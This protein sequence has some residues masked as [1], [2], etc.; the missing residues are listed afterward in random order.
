MPT[1]TLLTK[2]YDDFQLKQTREFLKT[3]LEGLKISTQIIGTMSRGW[4][5]IALSGEDEKV[6]LNFLAEEIGICPTSF[7]NIMRFSTVGGRI[8]S[9]NSRQNGLCIDIGLFSPNI[10]DATI[11]LQTLQAQIA[12]GRKVA[13]RKLIEL[14]GFLDDIPLEVKIQTL[15][16]EERRVEAELAERQL[17][18]YRNWMDSLLDRLFVCGASYD[19]IK[20]A[21]QNA[22]LERDIIDVEPL[23]MFEYAIV[24]KLGTDARGLIP[25]LGK[26]LHNAALAVFSPKKMRA[27][28]QTELLEEH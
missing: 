4:V 11:S 9:L 5:Q 21:L 1:V 19:E 14:F 16:E 2:A 15:K 26:P 12:K 23:G 22:S 20:F 8:T 10:V 24:C 17:E 13:L 25:R 6:A 28:L 7:G 18:I 3:K 27:F